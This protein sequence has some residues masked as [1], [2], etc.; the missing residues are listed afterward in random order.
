MSSFYRTLKAT[1]RV[2]DTTS[3]PQLSEMGRLKREAA[4]R[5][6]NLIIEGIPGPAEDDG[7]STAVSQ[8]KSFFTETLH[9]Y[10]FEIASAFRLGKLRQEATR[11]RSIKVQFLH[12]VDR[13]SSGGLKLF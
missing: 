9:L 4:A 1:D 11:P 2:N 6:C 13:E 7:V 12:P 3:N 5:K 10:E 8:V